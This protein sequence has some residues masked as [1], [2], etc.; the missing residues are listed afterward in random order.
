MIRKVNL[1]KLVVES[2]CDRGITKSSSQHKRRDG[3]A[4]GVCWCDWAE[5]GVAMPVGNSG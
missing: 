5:V 4:V 1:K 2:L 3:T